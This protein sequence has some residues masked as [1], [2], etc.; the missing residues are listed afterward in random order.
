MISAVATQLRPTAE[1]LE[2]VSTRLRHGGV[3]AD[4]L[5]E[6]ANYLETIAEHGHQICSLALEAI[7][8]TPPEHPAR[9]GDLE[10]ALGHS[11]D[12]FTAAIHFACEAA[13]SAGFAV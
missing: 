2:I 4:D 13:G 6:I 9:G 10:A 11:R 12:M 5:Y 1:Q 7:D 8:R 3:A